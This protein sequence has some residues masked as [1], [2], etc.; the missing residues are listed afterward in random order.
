MHFNI[1]IL[2]TIFSAPAPTKPVHHTDD[3]H[4]LHTGSELAIP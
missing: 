2:F 4:H 1:Y 3:I